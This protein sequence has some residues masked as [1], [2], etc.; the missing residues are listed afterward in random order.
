M[1]TQFTDF[2]SAIGDEVEDAE[3]GEQLLCFH[4][5]TTYYV[6]SVPVSPEVKKKKI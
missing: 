6:Y 4:S 3:E 5:N 1:S 2:L